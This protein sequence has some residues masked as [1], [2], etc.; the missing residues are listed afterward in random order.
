M[1]VHAVIGKTSFKV[2]TEESGNMTTP[3]TVEDLL[4]GSG[5][6]VMGRTEEARSKIK[7]DTAKEGTKCDK[8]EELTCRVPHSA[9][10]QIP[11]FKDKKTRTAVVPEPVIESLVTRDEFANEKVVRGKQLQT[12]VLKRKRQACTRSIVDGLA[13]LTS[14]SPSK[15]R[16]WSCMH[17]PLLA[18]SFLLAGTV[19]MST[20]TVVEETVEFK[21]CS[22]DPQQCTSLNLSDRGLTGTIPTELGVLTQLANL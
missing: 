15:G 18:L 9:A 5:D 11:D 14:I 4:C 17:V 10:V 7:E 3:A 8:S 19:Q 20:G 21:N 2:E 1:Q 12:T 6:P 13:H 16:K 22:S